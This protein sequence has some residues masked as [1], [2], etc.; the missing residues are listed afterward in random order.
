MFSLNLGS[1]LGSHSIS[2]AQLLLVNSNELGLFG[3]GLE[4]IQGNPIGLALQ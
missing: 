1:P 3:I 4:F 2:S